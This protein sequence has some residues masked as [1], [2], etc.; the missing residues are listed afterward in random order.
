M[1]FHLALLVPSG[2]HWL[3]NAPNVTC[4]D[5]TRQHSLDGYPLSCKQLGE[6]DGLNVEEGARQP[7]PRPCVRAPYFAPDC[8]DRAAGNVG[9]HS[10][11]P[12]LTPTEE[13]DGPRVLTGQCA[14][15]PLPDV[16]PY[17]GFAVL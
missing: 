5:S 11:G 3:D 1:S 15:R 10:G 13:V 12:V 17:V 14:S 4:K 6:I 16:F 2:P 8:P 9:R 7:S